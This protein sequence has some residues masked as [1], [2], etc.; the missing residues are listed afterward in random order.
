MTDIEAKVAVEHNTKHIKALLFDRGA[1]YP[2]VLPFW[3]S[4]NINLLFDEEEGYMSFAP[5]QKH[6]VVSLMERAIVISKQRI[7]NQLSQEG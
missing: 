1:T 6:N 4:N 5:E 7:E 3:D 2:D